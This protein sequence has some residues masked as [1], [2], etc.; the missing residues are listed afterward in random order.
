MASCPGEV[1]FSSNFRTSCLSHPSLR[2]LSNFDPSE[3]L[4][5][6]IIISDRAALLGSCSSSLK[7]L[8][9]GDN[10]GIFIILRT[11]FT[12]AS[13]CEVKAREALLDALTSK[14]FSYE[15]MTPLRSKPLA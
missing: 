8:D 2:I 3:I 12:C 6:Q 5:A 15:L 13:Q 14:I 11:I 1:L 4:L 10:P 9:F 7:S